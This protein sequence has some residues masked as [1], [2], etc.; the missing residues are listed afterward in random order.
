[1]RAHPHRADPRASPAVRDAERLVQVQVRDVGAERSGLGE[2]DERVEVRAVE[3][4]LT[5]VLVDRGAHVADVLLEDAVGRRIRDHER[6]ELRPVLVGLL[7]EVVEV[8]VAAVVARHDDDAHPRHRGARRVR[9]VR[10]CRDQADDASRLAAVAVEGADREQPGE[11]ALRAGVGLER[12][13][14]V[15]GDLAQ[16]AFEIREQLDVALRL[17]DRGER[18]HARRAPAT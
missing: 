10:R 15:A 17:L 3:V 6:G 9:A 4:H 5:A 16:P 18:V 7:L 8:D 1:M 13:R 12:H 2:T 11:L 14:V